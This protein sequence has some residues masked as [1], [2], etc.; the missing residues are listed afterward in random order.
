[1][2][3]QQIN[4]QSQL[5]QNPQSSSPGIHYS[6]SQQYIPNQ[7][8]GMYT[9]TSSTDSSTYSTASNKIASVNIS[10]NSYYDG[11]AQYPNTLTNPQTNYGSDQQNYM[12]NQTQVGYVPQSQNEMSHNYSTY[13][14]YQQPDT[15]TYKNS[16]GTGAIKNIPGYSEI[17]QS[18]AK[19]NSFSGYQ[20]NYYNPQEQYAG[21]SQYSNYSQGYSGNYGNVQQTSEMSGTSTDSY[22]G[23]PGYVYNALTGGYEYS[24]GYQNAQNLQGQ[25]QQ[26]TAVGGLP[27]AVNSPIYQQDGYMLYTSAGN[28]NVTNQTSS[29]QYSSQ[30]VNSTANNPTYYSSSQYSQQ[31]PTQGEFLV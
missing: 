21:S 24:S 27:G 19:A 5:V 9:N 2:L 7:H 16:Q 3:Q 28:N 30:N 4:P 1:M 14:N 11:A 18:H 29:T 17:I 13:G 12:S 31:T 25:E 15:N 23:H 10:S 20:T 8:M 22:Q 26:N 6:L